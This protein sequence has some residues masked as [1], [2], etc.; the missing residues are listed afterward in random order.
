MHLWELLVVYSWELLVVYRRVRT[1]AQ[2]LSLRQLLS[3]HVSQ[4]LSVRRF[5]P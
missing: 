4:R 3:Q 2:L 5:T 1:W